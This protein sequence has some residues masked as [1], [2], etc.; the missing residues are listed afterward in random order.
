MR[1]E[2][3]FSPN[4]KVVFRDSN[5]QGVVDCVIVTAGNGFKFISYDVIFGEKLYRLRENDLTKI[6]D[7]DVSFEKGND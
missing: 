7:N 4:D 3:K 6:K 5:I 2:T 1:I